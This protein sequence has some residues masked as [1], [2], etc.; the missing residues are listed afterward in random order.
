VPDFLNQRH[1]FILQYYN[2]A[3][4]DLSRHFN[5]GWQTI[6]IVAGGAVTLS[7]GQRGF[8]PIPLAVI[9]SMAIFAWG[10]WNVLDADYWALRAIAFLANVE[11]VYFYKDDQKVFNPYAGLHPPFKV[12]SSL[13]AQLYMV[14]ILIGVSILFYAKAIAERTDNFSLLFSRFSNIDMFNFLLWLSPIIVSLL[15]LKVLVS[16]RKERIVAYLSFV[17]DCPGPGLVRNRN[18]VRGVGLME[19]ISKADI[20][21]GEELQ[22]NTRK[23]LLKDQRKWEKIS[24]M[25]NLIMYLGC[26]AAV[27]MFIFKLL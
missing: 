2:M 1:E 13:K 21:S 20:I 23:N 12:L 16:V 22:K 15:S 24:M 5:I 3:V 4:Q 10:V 14:F 25:S 18:T 8:L 11:A 17:R 19:D 26:I 9:F 7:L 27:A 6:A